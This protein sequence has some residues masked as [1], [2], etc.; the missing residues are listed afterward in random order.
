MSFSTADYGFYLFSFLF[1][2]LFCL[3]SFS[4]LKLTVVVVAAAGNT[5]KHVDHSQHWP[6]TA[7]CFLNMDALVSHSL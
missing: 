6:E 3:V 5:V 4:F 1:I 7:A 2:V